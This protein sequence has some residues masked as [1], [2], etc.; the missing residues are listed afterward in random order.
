MLP[1]WTMYF[2]LPFMIIKT[3][4]VTRDM[5]TTLIKRHLK[6][7]EYHGPQNPWVSC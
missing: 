4:Q 6:I 3:I 5:P 7:L 2:F 1:I